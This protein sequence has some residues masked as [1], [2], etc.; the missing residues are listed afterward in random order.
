MERSNNKKKNFK[1]FITF[2][3]SYLLRKPDQKKF[4]WEDLKIIQNEIKKKK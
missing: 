3:P 4:S 1:T 2:H